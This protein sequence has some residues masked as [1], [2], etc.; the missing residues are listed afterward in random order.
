AP[1]AARL[2]EGAFTERTAPGGGGIDAKPGPAGMGPAASRDAAV[3][4]RRPRGPAIASAAVL[5]A[6]IAAAA[7]RLRR[8]D[9]V[10]EV[11]SAR[12]ARRDAHLLGSAGGAE[13]GPAARP[14]SR[15]RGPG[16]NSARRVVLGAPRRPRRR[17]E[18]AARRGRPTAGRPGLRRRGRNVPARALAAAEGH[19]ARQPLP[20][21]GHRLHPPGQARGGRAVLPALPAALHQSAGKAIPREDA[22]EV[23]PPPALK[24]YIPPLNETIP[25]AT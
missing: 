23:R 3:R 21:P 22:R 5:I 11:K 16:S 7:L 9:G 10:V 8:D 20:E 2:E 1:R 15:R 25:P 12:A 13:G 24:S 4:A 18:A 19:R 17:G 14:A 6:L